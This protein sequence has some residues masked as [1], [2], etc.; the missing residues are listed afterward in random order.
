MIDLTSEHDGQEPAPVANLST[1]KRQH[2]AGIVVPKTSLAG[3]SPPTA[4]KARVEEGSEVKP[5]KAARREESK[6]ADKRAPWKSEVDDEVAKMKA[7]HANELKMI[8][9]RQEKEMQDLEE[10]IEAERQKLVEEAAKAEETKECLQCSALLAP[11]GSFLVCSSCAGRFCDGHKGDMTTCTACDESYCK[12]CLKG[13]NVCAGCAL[14]PQLTC[15]DLAQMPCGEWEH[16]DCQ[17]YHHKHCRCERQ[18]R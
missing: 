11:G 15:C 6:K 10:R 13:M 7:K 8:K 18:G 17:Y 9:L 3:A 4:K 14:C 2:N 5:K 12:E 16:G 1:A